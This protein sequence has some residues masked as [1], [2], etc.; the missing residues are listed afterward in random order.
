MGCNYVV[1]GTHV[2]TINL[3]VNIIIYST[4]HTPYITKWC[5]CAVCWYVVTVLVAVHCNYTATVY[6]YDKY[7][8]KILYTVECA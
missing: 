1:D 2:S 8:L 7:N 4:V 6:Y 5:G 3:G